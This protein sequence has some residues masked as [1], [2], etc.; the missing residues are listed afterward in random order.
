MREHSSRLQV[1]TCLH[2][3]HAQHM[4]AAQRTEHSSHVHTQHTL[5]IPASCTPNV[6]AVCSLLGNIQHR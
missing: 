2:M 3:A 1:N 5:M 6:W 4:F